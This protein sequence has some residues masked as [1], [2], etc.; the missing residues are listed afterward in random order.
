MIFKENK[1]KAEAQRILDRV[2]EESE[3]IGRS[4]MRRVAESL[5]GHLGANDVKDDSWAEIW[6]TRIGRGL[7]LIFVVVLIFYLMQTYVFTG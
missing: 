4:S 5:S 2:S 3:T 1:N 6:G 7:G